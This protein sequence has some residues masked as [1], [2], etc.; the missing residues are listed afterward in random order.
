MSF[1][2]KAFRDAGGEVT[3]LVL[4]QGANTWIEPARS[5]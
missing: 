2:T 5:A 3:D 4:D 1:G